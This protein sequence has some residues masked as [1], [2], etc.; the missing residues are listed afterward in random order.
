MTNAAAT[1]NE[2]RSWGQAV[3]AEAG[4][5]DA[6]VDT[7]L[8][9]GHV[10]GLN[11]GEVEAKA[12]GSGALPDIDGCSPAE[13]VE[14]YRSLVERRATREPLQHILGVAYFRNLELSVGPGVFV[15][16][17]ETEMLVEYAI[18]SLRATAHAEPIAIDLG[19]G[20]GAIALAMATEVP[21]AKVYAVEKSREAATWTK[22][23]IAAYN[24]CVE[25]VVGD[26]AD[27]FPELVGRVSVVASNPPYIPAA[28]I[29]RDPEVRLFDPELALY[30]GEDGLDIVRT[31]SKRALELAH[32]GA[33]LII[34]HGELQG[35]D[36]RD[37]LA[38]DG[39][40]KP[41]TLLDLTMRDRY[42]RATRP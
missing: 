32:P 5:P 28:A 30:G 19:S 13:L 27:A 18:E 15:P 10:W 1:I 35:A 17:P 12:H 4:V 14:R 9:L 41:E 2:L 23:N 40:R 38:A 8:L 33:L 7:D 31:L 11:R 20:S 22:R 25:L 42:T 26:L 21:H 16:R 24:H 39:W 3:L 34:E 6:P 36:I 37:I 29:P